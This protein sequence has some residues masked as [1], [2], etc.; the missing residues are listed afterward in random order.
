MMR[1]TLAAGLAATGLVVFLSAG[2]AGLASIGQTAADK[3]QIV[4]G[5]PSRKYKVIKALAVS[6]KKGHPQYAYAD[7]NNVRWEMQK[8]AL[9]L[10]ADA[11]INV[12]YDDAPMG[13]WDW[14]SV[15]G[16]GLA[17]KYLE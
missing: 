3:I 12:K 9:A 16:T 4:E 11:V 6:I 5:S 15:S 1:R 14:G 8:Q 2:C 10:G 13:L 17:V 7:S